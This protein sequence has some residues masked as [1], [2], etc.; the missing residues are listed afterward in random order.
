[1]DYHTGSYCQECGNWTENTESFCESCKEKPLEQTQEVILPKGESWESYSIELDRYL[2]FEKIP[3]TMQDLVFGVRESLM[4]EGPL[5]R[6]P[7]LRSFIKKGR[8]IFPVQTQKIP[9]PQSCF[10]CHMPLYLAFRV[11]DLHPVLACKRCARLYLSEP[12]KRLLIQ[13][14]WLLSG[15]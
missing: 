15:V 8:V 1:M 6:A 3:E 9:S 13:M 4:L 5:S 7:T 14:R 2:H 11:S 12:T 10:Q